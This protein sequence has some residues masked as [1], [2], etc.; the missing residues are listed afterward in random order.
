MIFTG[1]QNALAAIVYGGQSFAAMAPALQVEGDRA[2]AE[3]FVRLFPLPP[4][5]PSTVSP[6]TPASS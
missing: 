1:D 3:Q 6:A 2:L 5:A 4:K